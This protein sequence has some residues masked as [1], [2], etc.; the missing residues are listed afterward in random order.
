MNWITNLKR[1][2]KKVTQTHDIPDDLW[3]KCAGCGSL[4]FHAEVEKNNFI[5]PNCGYH[6]RLAP[7]KRLEMMFDGGQ[8]TLIQ[9]PSITVH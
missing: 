8:F 3:D 9:L 4:L 2:V 1:P 7:L 6:F 5:C